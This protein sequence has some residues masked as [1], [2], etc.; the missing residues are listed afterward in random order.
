MHFE[1]WKQQHH[2]DYGVA[3]ANPIFLN[4]T[5]FKPADLD[6]KYFFSF[7]SCHLL[8]WSSR[9][10]FCPLTV[11]QLERNFLTNVDDFQK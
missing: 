6:C 3:E 1:L 2:S 8:I 7:F 5:F 9:A 10:S 11:E 4:L